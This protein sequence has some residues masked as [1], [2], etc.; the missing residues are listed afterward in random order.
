MSGFGALSSAPHLQRLDV[1]R[2]IILGALLGLYLLLEVVQPLEQHLLIQQHAL[3]LR[4]AVLQCLLQ[5]G[6]LQHQGKRHLQVRRVPRLPMEGLRG[7]HGDPQ[8]ASPCPTS[9]C[10]R[11]MLNCIFSTSA[12]RSLACFWESMISFRDFSLN[13]SSCDFSM[14]SELRDSSVIFSSCGRAGTAQGLGT[15]LCTLS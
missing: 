3:P 11:P 10:S 4:L 14:A 12:P 7:Q 8:R 1:P 6:N 9:S 5:P 2:A 13:S 15:S